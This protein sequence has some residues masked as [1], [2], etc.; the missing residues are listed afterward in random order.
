HRNITIVV[1]RGTTRRAGVHAVVAALRDHPEI[2]VLSAPHQ[3]PGR[4]QHPPMP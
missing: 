2:P 4:E 3:H 1:R